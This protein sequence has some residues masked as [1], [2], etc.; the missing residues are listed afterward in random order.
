MTRE[1]AEAIYNAGRETVVGTLL[2]MGQKLEEITT[3]LHLIDDEVREM[4]ERLAKNSRNSS[5]APSSDACKTPARKRLRKRGNR[6]PGA[7]KGHN[8]GARKDI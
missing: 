7:R 6:K 8:P 3:H 4:E 5:K 2:T 1:E